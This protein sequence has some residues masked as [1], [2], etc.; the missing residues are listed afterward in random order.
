MS[1]P[2]TRLWR[3][4][5]PLILFILGCPSSPPDS[6]PPPTGII[7][8]GQVAEFTPGGQANFLVQVLDPYTQQPQKEAALEVALGPTDGETTTVFHGV[9]DQQGLAQVSFDVPIVDDPHQRLTVR[10][11]TPNS[12]L[13]AGAITY[14]G[15]VYQILVSSDKPVYQPGQTIH[16]R[17]LALAASALKPA[18]G[19]A[20][21]LTVQDPAGNKLMRQEL[22]TSAYGVAAAD[23]VLDSEA[24]S[25]DYQ[26]SA[27]L[28]PAVSTRRVEVKPYTLPQFKVTFASD[29][30]YYLPG[31]QATGVVEAHYFFGKPVVAGQVTIRG[32]VSDE[33][34]SQVLET[35][36][37]TDE[38]GRFDAAITI[39]DSF[40]G[41]LTNR[42]ATV[43]L[44]IEVVDEANHAERTDESVTVAE[45]P[46][47]IEVAPESGSLR[48][49]LENIV[50]LHTSYPDGQD[51]QTELTVTSNDGISA[52]LRTDE[53]GL[54]AVPISV[55]TH[56]S[57]QLIVSASD[58]R[59]LASEQPLWL[60]G[61]PTETSGLLRPA[62]SACTGA[63]KPS[64]ARRC[65]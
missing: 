1:Q 32:F 54:A 31:E 23:F 10:A 61:D 65:S 18:Q 19:E 43:D 47:L 22:T 34:R 39:P 49:G 11:V 27:E 44:E 40:R 17:T 13:E 8:Y 26:I 6:G 20:L 37:I 52:T 16:L 7:L 5:L 14:V 35:T 56:S 15:P 9:T 29:K 50:Y 57:L 38:E 64:A 60:Y 59:G 41:R 12:T 3:M 36:G 58:R 51:A 24:A 21:T 63:W 46:I 4:L 45:Q 42:S 30:P 53:Y 28:G 2:R 25:G 48:P 55:P 33:E 62:T